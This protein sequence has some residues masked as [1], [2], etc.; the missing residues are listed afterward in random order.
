MNFFQKGLLSPL[1]LQRYFTQVHLR[2][3]KTRKPW[4]LG[5]YF[6]PSQTH[7]PVVILTAGISFEV[8][9]LLRKL[10]G[11]IN[12]IKWSGMEPYRQVDMQVECVL[13]YEL[14]QVQLCQLFKI[15]YLKQYRRQCM[16]SVLI[17]NDCFVCKSTGSG[18]TFAV[19]F[20][21]DSH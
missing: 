3:R 20:H 10:L 4:N 13:V 7:L 18:N 12:K 19:V 9:V 8:I 1:L 11:K 21:K 5:N 15:K 17:K 14:I 6:L 16:V 2:E